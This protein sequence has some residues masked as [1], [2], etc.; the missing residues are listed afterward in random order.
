MVQVDEK[1]VLVHYSSG[2]T[3]LHFA[4]VCEYQK[5][6][7]LEKEIP[8]KDRPRIEDVVTRNRPFPIKGVMFN[9]D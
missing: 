4:S 5:G 8:L 1:D 9:L 6:D 7:N 2:A 3:Q